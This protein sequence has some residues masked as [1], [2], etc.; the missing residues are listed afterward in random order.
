MFQLHTASNVP[1][2]FAQELLPYQM[3]KKFLVIKIY[4]PHLIVIYAI[5]HAAH[6]KIA[7]PTKY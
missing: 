5:K 3:A 7:M 4:Q 6:K 2:T 1:R